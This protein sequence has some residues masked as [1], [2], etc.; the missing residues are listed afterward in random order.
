MA[1]DG[2]GTGQQDQRPK[3]RFLADSRGLF[4]WVRMSGF[5]RIAT[6][7][8]LGRM[9]LQGRTR[10]FPGHVWR[11][12]MSHSNELHPPAT[13]RHLSISETAIFKVRSMYL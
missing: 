2:Q 3:G 5:Y 6:I 11:W 8:N 1:S 4:I 10:L 13:Y 9:S 7:G 12:I